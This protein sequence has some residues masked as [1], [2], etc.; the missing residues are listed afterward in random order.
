MSNIKDDP[1]DPAAVLLFDPELVIGCS[2]YQQPLLMP[3]LIKFLAGYLCRY[4]VPA[5]GLDAD[6]FSDE[7]IGVEPEYQLVQPGNQKPFEGMALDLDSD[8]LFLGNASGVRHKAVHAPG[9]VHE[10]IFKGP[11]E[12]LYAC[13]PGDIDDLIVLHGK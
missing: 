11:P 1:R 10:E 4:P 13:I 7:S 6:L 12:S 5:E 8:R 3:L 9:G 2:L